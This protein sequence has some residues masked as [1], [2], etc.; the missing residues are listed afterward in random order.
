MV[1]AVLE[2][3]VLLTTVQFSPEMQHMMDDSLINK[4]ENLPDPVDK[5]L[6]GEFAIAG[7]VAYRRMAGADKVN[8][9][10]S[11]DYYIFLLFEKS[12][13]THTIDFVEYR[14]RNYQVHISLPGQIH[15]WDTGPDTRGHKLLISK[16]LAEMSSFAPQFSCITSSHSPVIDIS[17]DTFEQLSSEFL[18]VEKELESFPVWWD[19]IS[20]RVQLIVVLINQLAKEQIKGAAKKSASLTLVKFHNLVEQQYKEIRTVSDYAARLFVTPN[21]LSIL[22]K[23]HFGISAKECIN[24][25][26]LLESKRLLLGSDV[27]IKDIAFTLG[28]NDIASFSNYIKSKTGFTP[29]ELRS[30]QDH[31]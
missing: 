2:L 27:A 25:R 16:R 14:Q 15:S 24:L 20:L 12:S 26:M 19:I 29:R 5:D 21:Y 30:F 13:G 18:A 23:R 9:F 4:P 6:D 7:N 8:N 10:R 17:T 22:C 3:N 31:N 11:P 28:F 1:I